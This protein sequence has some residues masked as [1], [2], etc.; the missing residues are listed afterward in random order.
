MAIFISPGEASY[1]KEMGRE[2]K[3][4]ENIVWGGIQKGG[5]KAWNLTM[6]S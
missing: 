5:R 6:E 3:D 1:C 4:G 2:L